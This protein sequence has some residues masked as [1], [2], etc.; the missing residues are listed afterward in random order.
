[1]LNY[2]NIKEDYIRKDTSS[3]FWLVNTNKLV[4]KVNGLNG[5]KTGYTSFSGYCITLHMTEGNM[6]LISVVMGYENALKRNSESLE[7]LRYGFNNYKLD[8]IISKGDIIE[9][10]D[11][12][13]YKNRIS[14]VVENDIYNVCKRSEKNNYTNKYE[15]VLT[16][17]KLNGSIDIYLDDIKIGSSNLNTNNL[18][19]KGFFDLIFSLIK[20]AI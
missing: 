2:T 9:S 1:V 16:D 19:K 17:S 7:L 18:D 3:P 12:I 14:I 10:I 5:L 20:K 8:K 15:Y 4:G 6:S 13:L 11:H